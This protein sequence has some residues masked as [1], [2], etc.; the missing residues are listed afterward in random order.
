TSLASFRLAPYQSGET[1]PMSTADFRPSRRHMLAS[2]AAMTAVPLALS[3]LVTPAQAAA[4]A[5]LGAWQPRHWRYKVGAFEL[6]TIADSEV[7]IDGPFP[8]I[9]G[10]APEA[11]VL[12]LMRESL[13]PERKYQPG[14]SPMIVN[15]G[16]DLVLFDTGNGE[17]GFVPR[18]AG[19]WL[20]KGLEPAG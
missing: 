5:K 4:P 14:F 11:D 2:A 19:G 10:S 17:N 9:G 3:T 12:A 7:F 1:T 18:P 6:T 15:T 16:S 13:L 20:A 8:L